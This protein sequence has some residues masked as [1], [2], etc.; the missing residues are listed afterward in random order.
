MSAEKPVEAK[1]TCFV[2]MGF[3]KKQ[4]FETNRTLDLDK[5]YLTIIKPAV[6]EAGLKCVRAD[7]IVHSG[8]IDVPMYEQLLS[9]D[10]V[11]A[12]LS[13]ANNNAFYELGVRH[14]LRPYTTIIICENEMTKEGRKLPFDVNRVVVRQY[15]HLGEAIDYDEVLRFR[16]VLKEAVRGILT[17]QPPDSDSPV[18]TFLSGLNPPARIAEE[19]GRKM[20]KALGAAQADEQHNDTQTHSVL[21]QQAED[22]QKEG[23]FERAKT[24]LGAVRVMRPDDAHVIHRLAMATYK[25][26]NPTTLQALE[27]ARE[28][29][30]TLHP[31]CSNDTWTLGLWGTVHEKLWKETRDKAYLDEALRAYK[32]GFNLRRDYYNG[33]H[34]AFVRNVRAA[35]STDPAEAITDFV[36]AQRIR[37]EVIPIC[38][39]WLKSTRPP[40]GKSDPAKRAL[41]EYLKEKSYVLAKLA[42][43]YLGTGDEEKAQQLFDDSEAVI[44]QLINNKYPAFKIKK[45]R[46]GLKR[47]REDLQALLADS[48]LKYIK[49]DA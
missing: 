13:T 33:I 43:A 10:V 29:L 37:R 6:E 28:L 5:T 17:K 18:Y 39:E 36:L 41:N 38:E 34:E 12:D 15:R 22:A 49:T 32:R 23:D 3:G 24:L 11:I 19:V 25:S 21:M 45:M 1:G 40:S 16:K 2:V 44:Q 20:D 9:A 35:N 30:K 26:C 8:L 27:K 48:P 7:E 4:D 31:D 46:D 14:A 42:E 47:K